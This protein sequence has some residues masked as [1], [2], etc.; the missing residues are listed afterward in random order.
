MK[1]SYILS[2]YMFKPAIYPIEC[3]LLRDISYYGDCIYCE[4]AGYL[5]QIPYDDEESY[6]TVYKFK[7]EY[8]GNT[9]LVGRDW[10]EAPEPDK[11]EKARDLKSKSNFGF[12]DIVAY[13]INMKKTNFR[14][15]SPPPPG[16]CLFSVPFFSVPCA[17]M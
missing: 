3:D 11:V 15:F 14:G 7:C 9:F 12:F 4:E 6:H 2:E 10:V 1:I 13:R 5:E 17:E 16:G 8:C